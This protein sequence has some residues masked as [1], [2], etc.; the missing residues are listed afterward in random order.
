MGEQLRASTIIA[1]GVAFLTANVTAQAGEPRQPP[2][3]AAQPSGDKTAGSS[4]QNP[5]PAGPVTAS[6]Y[7]TQDGEIE[8]SHLI[9]TAIFNDQNQ[10][11]G[12]V[13]DVL[14]DKTDKAVTAVLSVGGFLGVGSRLVAVPFGQIQIR[15]DKVVVPGATKVSLENLPAYRGDRG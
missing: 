5:A 11:I 3:S 7:L 15:T 9:G 8:A 6:K 4:S 10:Q 14:L 2:Q 1:L 13:S 12:T